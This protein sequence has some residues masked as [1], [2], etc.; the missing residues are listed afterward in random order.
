MPTYKNE[1]AYPVAEKGIYFAPGQTHKTDYILTDSR[2]TKLLDSPYYNPTL[3]I[4]SLISTGP[5]D[6]KTVTLNTNTT[7]V[8]IW[9]IV[10][11]TVSV[12]LNHTDAGLTI[13][14]P[15]GY[16]VTLPEIKGRVTTILLKFAHGGTCELV[17]VE[18]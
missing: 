10:G 2:L 11:A 6:D 8:L 14:L 12:Y 18:G 1:T 9:K 7:E 15:E 13:A 3:A 17:E 16:E 4:H 5:D